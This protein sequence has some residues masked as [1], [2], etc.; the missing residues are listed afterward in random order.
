M[1]FGQAPQDGRGGR[2]K[3][4]RQAGDVAR[5]GFPKSVERLETF[6]Q[7]LLPIADALCR[8]GHRPADFKTH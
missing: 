3:G 2:V 6:L 1:T 5:Y 4:A 8:W 7:G